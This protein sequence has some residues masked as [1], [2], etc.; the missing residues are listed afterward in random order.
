MGKKVCC[1]DSVKIL[2]N[3]ILSAILIVFAM[4]LISVPA[5][6]SETTYDDDSKKNLDDTDVTYRIVGGGKERV[7]GNYFT[8]PKNKSSESE[9]IV[10]IL[11]N[12]NRSQVDK[13][14]DKSFITIE[15][16]NYVIIKLR[17]KNIIRAGEN[18]Q[19]GSNDGMSA[20]HVAKG[21]TMKVT[22]E[23]GDGSESGSLEAYGGGGKYGGAGIGTRYN[24]DTGT[25][26]IAGG[27]I[28][29]TG[30]HS[31]AGI[32]SGR[33]GAAKKILIT[34]GNITAQGGDYGAGIGAGDNVDTGKGGDLYDLSITGG[35]VNASGGKSV[36]M[37]AKLAKEYDEAMIASN[38]A[39]DQDMLVVDP[40]T[41]EVIEPLK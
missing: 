36:A 40:D 32:G 6:A 26:I 13:S 18:K 12:V 33:D 39:A 8:V 14:P 35:T 38:M 17:G 20:L 22:S 37:M 30:G 11:D 15:E 9:P 31:A 16:G 2:V 25:I 21:S 7:N 4:V 23:E 27:T 28:K 10:I 19:L 41:G 1:H 34:G 3:T 5:F 29:A 24:D